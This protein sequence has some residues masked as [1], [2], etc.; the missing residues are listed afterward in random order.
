MS[1]WSTLGMKLSIPRFVKA[2][3]EENL[4]ILSLVIAISINLNL[5]QDPPKMYFLVEN[6]T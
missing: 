6:N 3:H 2:R 1:M 4:L 5:A